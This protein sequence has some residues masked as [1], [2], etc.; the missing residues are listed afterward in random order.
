[1]SSSYKT[2]DYGTRVNSLTTHPLTYCLGDTMQQRMMHGGHS[3]ALGKHSRECQYFMPQYCSEK[4]D[5]FCE[6]ASQ[7][8]SSS[9]FPHA[10]MDCRASNA[11]HLSELTYGQKLIY[12]TAQ[13]K[14]LVEMRGLNPEKHYER[15]DPTVASSPMITYWTGQRY[16]VFAITSPDT[17]D[18]DPVMNKLLDTPTIAPDILKNIYTTMKHRGMLKTLQG[19]RLDRF[20]QKNHTFFEKN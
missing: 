20:F 2:S 14:Y 6:A 12:T 17:L 7:D 19:T 8:C 4:W 16:P 5:A 9:Y 10:D 11:M 1:M 3:D 18:S 13:R 15:F